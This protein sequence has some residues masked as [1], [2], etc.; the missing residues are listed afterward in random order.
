MMATGTVVSLEEYLSIVYEPDCEFVDGELVERNMGEFDH[1]GLQMIIAAH[2]YNQR[3]EYGIYVFPELRVQVAA[4]RYRIPDITVTKQKG[5][6]R[7]LR[8]PL[9]IC[10]RPSAFINRQRCAPGRINPDANDLSRIKTA[11]VCFRVRE[12][13]L[14]AYLRAFHIIRR[15][16]PRQ[17]W[18]ATQDDARISMLI[19]PN[20]VGNFLAVSDTDQECAHGI[21]PIIEADGI[22]RAH[23][24]FGQW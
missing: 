6:G 11:L 8:E 3:R 1:A 21:C 19:F 16:L 7:I 9:V 14:D 2:M 15:M 17:I 18:I 22:S 23:N 4:T 24:F 13:A 20:G 12:C 10:E 5:H